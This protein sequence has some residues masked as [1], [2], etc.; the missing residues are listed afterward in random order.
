MRLTER[1]W[2]LMGAAAIGGL[3]TGLL[4]GWFLR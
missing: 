4:Y 1:A 2:L 3:F